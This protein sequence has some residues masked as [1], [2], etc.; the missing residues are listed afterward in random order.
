MVGGTVFTLNRRKKILAGMGCS[1]RVV[2]SRPGDY[3]E[4]SMIYG[5]ITEEGEV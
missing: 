3:H 1:L 5:F 2:K 4:G